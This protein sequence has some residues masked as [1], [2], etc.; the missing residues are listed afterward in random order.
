MA[1]QSTGIPAERQKP[2]AYSIN[3]GVAAIAVS[4]HQLKEFRK[5]KESFL[6]S[7]SMNQ[8]SPSKISF[9]FFFFLC[10]EAYLKGNLTIHQK[11]KGDFN[12]YQKRK[13]KGDFNKI[14]LPEH[15]GW[16]T[17]CCTKHGL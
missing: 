3:I 5:G 6:K 2:L 17:H 14:A 1:S 12:T 13:R 10:R 15:Q 9:S 7:T 16:S 8:S 11:R 4:T